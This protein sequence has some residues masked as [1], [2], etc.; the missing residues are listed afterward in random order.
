MTRTSRR[1]APDTAITA[2]A[3]VATAAGTERY[4]RRHA[5][6]VA[7]D[8]FRALSDGTACSSI[9]IGT[10]LGECDD[11][12]DAR[13]AAA[14]S[15]ALATGINV[16]D[17]AINYRCQRSERAVG[18][19]L[20]D[21]ARRKVA[22]DGILICTKGGYIPLDDEPPASREAYQ[23]YLRRDFF[24][25]GIMTPADVVAGGHCLAPRYLAHQIE[26]SRENLGVGTIDLY[27]LHNP[28]QQLGA[29]A[30]PALRDRIRSA[31]ELL[32]DR[33]AAGEIARYG[34]ATWAGLRV[35][36]DDRSHLPLAE[37]VALARD[38]AGA[39]HHFAA[40]QLPINLAMPEAVRTPTQRLEGTSSPVPLVE[41]AAALG[42]AVFASA[43]LLQGRLTAG[44]PRAVGDAFPGLG[45]DAQRALAFARSIPGVTTALVGMKTVAHVEHNLEAV[46]RR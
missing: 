21:A 26:R 29:I 24:D 45:T 18:R 17:T 34:C 10:Y 23:A 46:R 43:S 13:Y 38:V 15:H 27:Y 16:V 40:V 42:V 7:D 9:G 6:A 5:A 25:P 12:D 36:P 20:R 28:E 3:D 19:A 4:R 37:L 8:H 32:E 1:G 14:V 22:R 31:F 30:W 11:A 2:A 41:A 33:V 39:S 44:L 35:P